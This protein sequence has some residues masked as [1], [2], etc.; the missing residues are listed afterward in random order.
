[1]RGWS[2]W[3]A[4]NK[5]NIVDFLQISIAFYELVLSYGLLTLSLSIVLSNDIA[6]FEG[7]F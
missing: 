7:E 6:T 2:K 4:V 5:T 3:P 1:M